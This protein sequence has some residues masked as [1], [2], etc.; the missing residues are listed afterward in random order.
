MANFYSGGLANS[1][2]EGIDKADETRLKYTMMNKQMEMDL[3]KKKAETESGYQLQ[4]QYAPGIEAAKKTAELGA[5]AEAQNIPKDE[6]TRIASIL[7]SAA[8]SV[9]Q[10]KPVEGLDFTGISSTQGQQAAL[11]GIKEILTSKGLQG[12]GLQFIHQVNPDGTVTT[13][14]VNRKNG[15]PVSN[16]N[17]G[18]SPKAA[19][20]IAAGRHSYFALKHFADYTQQKLHQFVTA[21]DMLSSAYQRGTL[22]LNQ[23]TQA[24]PEAKA[25]IDQLPYDAA[26]LDKTTLG[27]VRV[28]GMKMI[29]ATKDAIFNKGDT[30]QTV[31]QKMQHFRDLGMRELRGQYDAHTMQYPKD[32]PEAQQYSGQ[33]AWTQQ[34]PGV[35]PSQPGQ[36]Q[37]AQSAGQ[38]AFQ[39]SGMSPID[40]LRQKYK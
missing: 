10:G 38:Q 32:V 29:D 11:N 27:S 31:D 3:A 28:G 14:G 34:Q 4:A 18:V 16:Y 9:A 5:Q 24:S 13:V 37:S 40:A 21:N 1:L 7:S 33:S 17:T 15:Q 20:D 12:Q 30:L 26:S 25:F 2:A 22:T 36:P 8:N 35:Q 23:L 6:F 19:S 39:Q